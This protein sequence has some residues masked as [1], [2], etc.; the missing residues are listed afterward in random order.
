RAARVG[1]LYSRP[2]E[3]LRTVRSKTN[4]R[5]RTGPSKSGSVHTEQSGL[6]PPE[7]SAVRRGS[8]FVQKA[9]A[10]L[11]PGPPAPAALS[12]RI[13]ELRSSRR[14]GTV[15]LRQPSPQL[16]KKKPGK[17]QRLTRSRRRRY[18]A[19]APTQRG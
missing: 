7:P 4:G 14:W 10:I 17:L 5:D 2:V 9:R 19:P 6:V 12:R 16:Q 18:A 3:A 11:D 13:P 8:S 1:S 15:H